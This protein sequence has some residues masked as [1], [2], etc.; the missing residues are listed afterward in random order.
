M[1][2][3]KLRVSV[4][5][6]AEYMTG[7]PSAKSNIIEQLLEDE[8]DPNKNWYSEFPTAFSN[9]LS[10]QDFY[11]TLG[12][13][14]NILIRR[15]TSNTRADDKAIKQLEAIDAVAE[16]AL[17]KTLP[18]ADYFDI[19]RTKNK[20]TIGEC[21]LT[22]GASNYAQIKVNGLTKIGAI[23]P[24]L[25]STKP[26][27]AQTAKIHTT[28]LHWLSEKH[29]RQFGI[30]DCNC[31]AVVDVFEKKVFF[32]TKNYKQMRIQITVTLDEIYERVQYRLLTKSSYKEE[33][34]A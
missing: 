9:Y 5:Q 26:L 15:P 23:S 3:S 25:K 28:A 20:L 17:L 34:R 29:Y 22:T 13:L 10:K 1:P 21:V 24:Y 16:M 8:F 19:P 31:C 30:P 2:S 7:T 14:K 4:K 6:L 12:S 33:Q 32:G 11:T 18:L 27:D